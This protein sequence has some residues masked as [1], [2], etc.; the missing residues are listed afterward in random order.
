MFQTTNQKWRCTSSYLRIYPS[1]L[2]VC[3]T[4]IVAHLTQ[5][6][7]ALHHFLGATWFEARDEQIEMMGNTKEVDHFTAIVMGIYQWSVE[8]WPLKCWPSTHSG[9]IQMWSAECQQDVL[10]TICTR[11]SMNEQQPPSLW[12]SP[13]IL[14]WKLKSGLTSDMANKHLEQGTVLIY[15]P[16][17]MAET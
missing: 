15:V 10:G 1:R 14:C 6:P 8:Q 13:S 12:D 9:K 16:Q 4:V 11:Q 3:W 17:F 5:T 2:E 7:P